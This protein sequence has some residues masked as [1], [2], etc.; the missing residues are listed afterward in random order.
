M[1]DC[2]AVAWTVPPDAT[3][4]PAPN[5]NTRFETLVQDTAATPQLLGSKESRL[6]LPPD[7][8]YQPILAWFFPFLLPACLNLEKKSS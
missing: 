6:P 7:W 4:P 5:H 3:T 1:P 2:P 8:C